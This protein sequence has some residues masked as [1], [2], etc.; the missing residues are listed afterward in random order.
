MV[1]DRLGRRK[2]YL[3]VIN[4][5]MD[6]FGRTYEDVSNGSTVPVYRAASATPCHNEGKEYEENEEIEYL[7]KYDKFYENVGSEFNAIYRLACCAGTQSS[8]SQSEAG[9]KCN[10][11]CYLVTG[12]EIYDSGESTSF[13]RYMTMGGLSEDEPEE[14]AVNVWD[15]L[16]ESQVQEIKAYFRSVHSNKEYFDKWFS[17][18]LNSVNSRDDQKRLAPDR[19][20]IARWYYAQNISSSNRGLDISLARSTYSHFCQGANII[21][22]GGSYYSNAANI[23]FG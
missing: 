12:I 14:G 19:D 6:A 9:G 2:L 22:L 11:C 18:S 3:C 23:E 4:I 17:T 5:I 16:T 20:K 13:F 10:W 1:G 7:K 8:A 21:T 15:E